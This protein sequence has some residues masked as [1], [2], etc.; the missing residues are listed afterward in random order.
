MG[1][2]ELRASRRQV[3]ADTRNE[4]CVAAKSALLVLPFY[5]KS[6][7]GSLGKHMLTPALSLSAVAA[8]TP[9]NWRVRIWDENLLQGS[10]P[11]DPVP[12]VVGMTVHLTFAQRAYDLAA[13]YRARG[14]RV[15]L[16]GLHV[17]SRASELHT[18]RASPLVSPG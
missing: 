3:L 14:A 18:A 9:A 1:I 2:F 7:Y 10:P 15:I 6:R 4:R 12:E 13:W 16:G 11:Q 5:P 8:A 17:Q